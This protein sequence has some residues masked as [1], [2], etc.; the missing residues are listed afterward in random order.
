MN[1]IIQ[2]IG[3]GL[4]GT[5][6]AWSLAR[7][8]FPVHLHEM[9]PERTSPAHKTDGLAELVC[10]NSLRSKST[11][12]A[13]GILKREMVHLKSLVM[14]AALNAQVPAGDAL[15]VNRE[16]FSLYITQ[17]IQNE[18]CITLNRG[19]V[20]D[21]QKLLDQG[22]VVIATGPLT[23]N[24]LAKEL[25]P[26]VGENQLY[27]YDAISPI[28]DGSTID[29]EKVF[30]ASRYDKG[31]GDDYLNCPLNKEEYYN[32]V[33]Q[34]RNGQKVLLKSFEK[35]IYFEGCLPAE[36][37]A[38]RGDLT[39]AFGPM[40]PVGLKHPKTG[41]T[42][43]AV[44]QL[45]KEDREGTAYNMVG[46]QT[47]LTYPEQKRI[48]RLIPGLEQAEF[49]RLGCIHRNTYIDSPRVM[50]RSFQ[51]KKE[52]RIRFAGQI[53]GA[54][55]YVESAALGLFLGHML[56]FEL[57]GKPFTL[58]PPST[59]LGALSHYLTEHP[60]KNFQPMNVNFGIF[61]ALP[62]H[63]RSRRRVGG[64]SARKDA[65]DLRAQK[66]FET[67]LAQHG[68]LAQKIP[69]M[70]SLDRSHSIRI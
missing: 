25:T 33:R 68:L 38:E 59:A 14:E 16:H 60:H 41:E 24:A 65:Y 69:Q 63:I 47:K 20:T 1:Q 42:P 26:L 62:S 66:D 12:K 9:R 67:W 19:E 51:L 11:T 27:F 53:M 13:V 3:G 21:L 61:S 44:V 29:F 54:E 40:K 37:M 58:P 30:K 57:Q 56:A 36:V 6:A 31:E 45:R 7:F 2:I 55:G 28:I 18:P 48:F 15:A 34:L 10:S 39:L 46:F 43:F 5:E 50:N 4:A 49:F 8:G 23:S 52:P 64:K 22:P 32:L 17:K 35:A 70:P